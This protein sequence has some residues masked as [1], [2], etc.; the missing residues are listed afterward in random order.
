[1]YRSFYIVGLGISTSRGPLQF[2][3]VSDNVCG[4]IWPLSA[5]NINLR[6]GLNINLGCSIKSPKKSGRNI[7]S[8]KDACKVF[9]ENDRMNKRKTGRKHK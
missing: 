6:F 9:D 7:P 8:L 4:F 2:Y 1:M 3:M 5:R